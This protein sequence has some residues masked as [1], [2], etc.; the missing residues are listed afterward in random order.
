MSSQ[1]IKRKNNEINLKLN[2]PNIFQT[3]YQSTKEFLSK[4]NPKRK[5]NRELSKVILKGKLFGLINKSNIMTD[6][7]FNDV[8]IKL[9][10]SQIEKYKV[11][12]KKLNEK[13]YYAKNNPNIL[14]FCKSSSKFEDDYINMRD[15]LNKKFTPD[16][17]RTI[18][19]F[20]QF[21]Q[22]NSNV[23]LKELVEEK[24]K[25]LYEIL[26]IEEKKEL[27]KKRMKR[28]KRLSI[29]SQRRRS[30][31]LN[32]EFNNTKN[33]IKELNNKNDNKSRNFLYSNSLFKK[34][35]TTSKIKTTTYTNNTVTK[36]YGGERKFNFP[37]IKDDGKYFHNDMGKK[38]KILSNLIENQIIEKFEK[39]KKRKELISQ[40][41]R[42]KM[43]MIKE[44]NIREQ[45]KKEK[46]RLK[47]YHEKK[48]IEYIVDK[49]KKNYKQTN[50][51]NEEKEEES[52]NMIKEN[53]DEDNKNNFKNYY[54]SEF[55][56]ESHGNNIKSSIM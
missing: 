9:S 12:K 26:G 39:M 46:E 27:A 51:E 55:L 42:I 47:I 11:N 50:K 17:Q 53:K 16:E 6:E 13:F 36:T 8:K 24:H 2:D 7:Q 29:I 43:D 25:Y 20:P 28:R 1:N 30:T 34:N 31:I 5:V 35:N 45:N 54:I 14:T 23:F 37:L 49:L 3:K 40:N 56:K 21:F 10:L 15:L 44:K 38:Y 18:L 32:S 52:V 4:T 22:L 48:Y 33:I 19:S 41:N